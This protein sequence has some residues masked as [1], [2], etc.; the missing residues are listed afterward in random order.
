MSG[1]VIEPFTSIE[2]A[3]RNFHRLNEAL[4]A[5]QG[6]S[7]A[8]ENIEGYENLATKQNL[9][10]AINGVR[11]QVGDVHITEDPRYPGDKLGYGVWVRIAHSRCLVSINENDQDFQAVGQ[12]GGVKYVGLGIEHIP[13]H[14]HSISNREWSVDGGGG[15]NATWNDDDR[16]PATT[17][18]TNYA[19]GGQP[20]YNLQ[21]YYCVYIWKRTA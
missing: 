12:L 17:N 14:N 9:E 8:I 4:V 7:I 6:G 18:W 19:G 2:A 21:P 11:Y 15:A 1:V 16:S 3:E 13:P 20:H 5:L 10:D